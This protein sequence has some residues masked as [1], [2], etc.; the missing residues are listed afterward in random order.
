M[1]ILETF[2][3]GKPVVTS[4]QLPP[5]FVDLYNFVPEA[6]TV[7]GVPGLN[8]ASFKSFMI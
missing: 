6:Y 8:S 4:V 3:L 2:E 1:A 5:K 7:F